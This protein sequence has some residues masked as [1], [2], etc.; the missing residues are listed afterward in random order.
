MLEI[1]LRDRKRNEWLHE[2]T[3][4]KNLAER[5]KKR[6][7]ERVVDRIRMEL[8]RY[9]VFHWQPKVGREALAFHQSNGKMAFE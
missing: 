4:V 7:R 5:E 9:R 1:T 8:G 2:E 3:K 6:E